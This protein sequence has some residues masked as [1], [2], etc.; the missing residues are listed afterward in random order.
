MFEPWRKSVPS[1][2]CTAKNL[3]NIRKISSTHASRC[4][5]IF[6]NRKCTTPFALNAKTT[7][8]INKLHLYTVQQRSEWIQL[9]LPCHLIRKKS[10]FERQHSRSVPL[11]YLLQPDV[12]KLF[13]VATI[14]E[15][16]QQCRCCCIDIK[17]EKVKDVT[18]VEFC[19]KVFRK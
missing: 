15:T 13:S 1:L 7:S 3:R 10:A 16:I 9:N 17:N 12:S 11:A 5:E 2:F 4:F 8:Y 18:D 14:N 19:T 6:C